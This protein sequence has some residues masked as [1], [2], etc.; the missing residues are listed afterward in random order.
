MSQLYRQTQNECAPAAVLYA[1]GIRTDQL[2]PL[3]L[4]NEAAKIDQLP[5]NNMAEGGTQIEVCLHLLKQRGLIGDYANIGARWE[6]LD[7]YLAAGG[8]AV[9]SIPSQATTGGRVLRHAVVL[10]GELV[11]ARCYIDPSRCYY[12]P[13]IGDHQW[14]GWPRLQE[15]ILQGTLMP[16][17]YILDQGERRFVAKLAAKGKRRNLLTLGGLAAIIVALV[18]GWWLT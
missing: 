11:E 6:L 10:I 9:V 4:G 14:M 13:A 18:V 2:H 7:E 17:V 15:L 3:D 16:Q 5:G 12:D 1:A 8:K